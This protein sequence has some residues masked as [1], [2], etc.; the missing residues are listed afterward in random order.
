MPLELTE[1]ETRPGHCL[2]RRR[3]EIECVCMVFGSMGVGPKGSDGGLEESRG[4][5]LYVAAP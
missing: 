5:V 1:M 3:C 4:G 2:M